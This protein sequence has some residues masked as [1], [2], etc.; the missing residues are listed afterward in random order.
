MKKEGL[1][2]FIEKMLLVFM[3]SAFSG[4]LYEII[5]MYVMWGI[6]ADRGVLYL[7]MCPIYGFGMLLLYVVFHKVKNPILIFLGSGFITTSF[8]LISSYILEYVFHKVLWTY[9]TWPLNFQGRIS[10]VSS[11]IFGLLSLYVFKLV[12]P[13]VDKLYEKIDNKKI[14]MFMALLLA[15]CVIIQLYNMII[16]L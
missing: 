10:L 3:I 16:R 6:Y 1:Y 12:I 9:A 8:E 14:H 5:T 4:W 15:I 11:I 13:L 7:P 2:N